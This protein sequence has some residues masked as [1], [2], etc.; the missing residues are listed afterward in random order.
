MN[1]FLDYVKKYP[2]TVISVIIT[3]YF[4]FT[5]NS[6]STTGMYIIG[7]VHGMAISS[8]AEYYLIKMGKIIKVK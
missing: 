5:S 4:W 1:I 2:L 7:I 3:A 8:L 6:I